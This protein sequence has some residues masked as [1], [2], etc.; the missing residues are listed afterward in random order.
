[1]QIRVQNKRRSVRKSRYVGDVLDS[2]D[3][4]HLGVAHE[5]AGEGK[6]HGAKKGEGQGMHGI[7]RGSR[8]QS[9]RQEVARHDVGACHRAASCAGTG[10]KTGV[11]LV[12]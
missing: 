12:G 5:R 11:P 2:G 6:E 10:K 8:E 7:S 3:E 4:L 1:M 9:E